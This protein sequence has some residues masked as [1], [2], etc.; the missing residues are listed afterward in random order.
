MVKVEYDSVEKRYGDTIAVEDAEVTVEDGEFAVLLGPS[1]CGKTTTL[2]CLAGLTKPT[3]GNIFVD[4]TD[5]TDVHPKN[6][7][8]AMVFQNFALY[9][10]MTVGENI[11]YP[12]KIAGVSKEERDRR[13]EETADILQISELI[14]RSVGELS[15]GQRQRV[16]LGRAIVREPAVFL[17]DEPLANLD[18]KLK[19]G[20]RTRIKRLQRELDVTTLYVTHDQE[21]AMSLGDKLIVMDKG[22]VQQVGT[23]DEIY[24]Q[25]VNR[26][27][28]GFIGS[29][30]MNFLEVEKDGA[31][32]RPLIDGAEFEFELDDDIA[33]AYGTDGTF[34]LGIRPEH[35]A[36]RTTENPRCIPGTV[37]VTEPLGNEQH[38]DITFGDLSSEDLQ[39]TVTASGSLSVERGDTVW[40]EFEQEHLHAFEQSSGERIETEEIVQSK[41]NVPD[42]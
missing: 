16:A 25:P 17:M 33:S 6:R 2:R 23:G 4:G 8:I 41:P 39:F 27:V 31:V 37:E 18:A 29:P 22:N 42:S 34:T 32:V 12:L 5:I 1:G 28:A 7:N 35:V 26:F 9:P 24:H 30:A 15:G 38:I 14:D 36:V 3:D 19:M 20:M 21:E 40:L 10:H 13:V 11:G